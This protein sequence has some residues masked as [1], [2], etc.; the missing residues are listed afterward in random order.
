MAAKGAK[1][2]GHSRNDELRTPR[3]IYDWL[4]GRF[5]F[6][7]DG[8]ST[9]ENHLCQYF[10]TQDGTFW[11]PNWPDE[12]AVQ[13][14]AADGL[15]TPYLGM[16]VFINPPYSRPLLGQFIQKVVDEKDSA[17][18]IV[19]LTKVDTSTAWWRL[20]KANAHIEYLKRVSYDDENGN[21]LP[22]STFA[23]AIAILQPTEPR[24]PR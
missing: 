12:L 4:N 11:C 5:Q 22:P 3:Y 17:D 15:T 7:F 20:L 6:D 10:A 14:S 19:M 21:P 24:R 18:C 13:I 1:L 8:A 16:R 9:V 2:T 23:S